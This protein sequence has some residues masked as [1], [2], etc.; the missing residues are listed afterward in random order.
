MK[1][2]ELRQHSAPEL[3]KLIEDKL[4]EQFSLRTQRAL[5]QSIK[6]H[7]FSVARKVIARAKTILTEKGE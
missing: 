2:K 3:K 4:K 5:S 6:S 7:Q 1:A